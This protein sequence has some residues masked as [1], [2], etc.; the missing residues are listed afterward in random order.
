MEMRM[1]NLPKADAQ[2]ASPGS[3]PMVA[4]AQPV[5][6]P[7]ARVRSAK[8]AIAD[9]LR[10]GLGGFDRQAWLA[11]WRAAKSR[12]IAGVPFYCEAWCNAEWNARPAADVAFTVTEDA[13]DRQFY[14]FFPFAD[15]LGPTW[16][17]ERRRYEDTTL[18]EALGLAP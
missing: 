6:D 4:A 15:P 2:L 9:L 5:P 16:E 11:Q 8:L 18:A 12:A 14:R 7:P 1:R 13:L 17:V 10:R 3:S